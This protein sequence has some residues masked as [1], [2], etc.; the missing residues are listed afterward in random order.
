MTLLQLS[1]QTNCKHFLNRN[2][3]FTKK[4]VFDPRNI[5]FSIS[6]ERET[7]VQLNTSFSRRCLSYFV[8]LFSRLSIFVEQP[9]RPLE[10]V[11][12]KSFGLIRLKKC[13]FNCSILPITMPFYRFTAIFLVLTKPTDWSRQKNKITTNEL[14]WRHKK[15]QAIDRAATEPLYCHMPIFCSIFFID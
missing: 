4:L 11:N 14:V 9:C 13:W 12:A 3:K 7:N 6:T 5:C 10:F 1:F 15:G 2:V 8:S